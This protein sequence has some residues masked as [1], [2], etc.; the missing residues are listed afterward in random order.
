M[1][2]VDV[3][4]IVC[5]AYASLRLISNSVYVQHNERNKMEFKPKQK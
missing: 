3:R 1:E 2:P 4:I 5:T